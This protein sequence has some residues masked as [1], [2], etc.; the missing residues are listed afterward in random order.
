V[1]LESLSPSSQAESTSVETRELGPSQDLEARREIVIILM[2]KP[3]SVVPKQ[4]RAHR[5]SMASEIWREYEEWEEA[6]ATM[7]ITT[8]REG[9]DYLKHAKNLL[10][11]LLGIAEVHPIAKGEIVTISHQL[12]PEVRLLAVVSTFQTVI[13]FEN[14]RRE[15][16]I[17]VTAVFLAQ[18]D[19]LR[20]LLE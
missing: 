9:R 20:M 6:H 2:D 7:K 14:D 19:T 3:T 10:P 15:N 17:R 11:F 12:C 13:L 1:D 16:D 18:A 8:P 5:A 4:D